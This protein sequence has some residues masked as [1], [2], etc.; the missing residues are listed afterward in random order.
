MHTPGADGAAPISLVSVV[1]ALKVGGLCQM[2]R[3]A[4]L[5]ECLIY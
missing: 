2:P 4:I 3:A 5:A 1:L